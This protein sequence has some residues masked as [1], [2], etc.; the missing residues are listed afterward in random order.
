MSTNIDS[1]EKL[2]RS[3]YEAFVNLDGEYLSR[4][5]TQKTSTDMSA[6]KDIKW[7]RLDILD[8]QGDTVEFKAFYSEHG[9]MK[10]LHEK[11]SFV[12]VDGEWKY[13]DGKLF[14]TQISR[15]D[16]C[17]CGSEKKYK[18]CCAKL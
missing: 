9:E 5:T 14:S 17:P 13:K 16:I 2:M 12:Q 1:P 10:V 6:Y 18:K 4:T 7:L 3:R 15:N 11:S 8:A